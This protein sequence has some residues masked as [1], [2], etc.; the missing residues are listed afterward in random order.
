MVVG[1]DKVQINIKARL[2]NKA[3]LISAITLTVSFVYRFL[4]LADIFP[5]V[6]EN[7][8]LE[9]SGILVNVLAV[10]GVVVD[11]TTTGISDSDRAMTYY[12]NEND[13]EAVT[14]Y[15]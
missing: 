8:I 13:S 5:A 15:E 2:K 11:P 9:L 3:F 7:E 4:A 6:S 10:I 14:Y 12:S 1:D